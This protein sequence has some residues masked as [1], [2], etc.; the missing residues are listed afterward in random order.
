MFLPEEIMKIAF[1]EDVF[2]VTVNKLVAHT[3]QNMFPLIA[4]HSGFP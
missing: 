4:E 2:N 1:L 3:T